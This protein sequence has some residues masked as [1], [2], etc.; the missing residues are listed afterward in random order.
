MHLGYLKFNVEYLLTSEH[1]ATRTAR[2]RAKIIYFLRHVF[3][4]LVLTTNTVRGT[5][6]LLNIHYDTY[7]LF[8]QSVLIL[9][10]QISGVHRL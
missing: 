5:S 6:I 3:L 10:V 1:R 7:L 9:F 4:S 2:V 8:T